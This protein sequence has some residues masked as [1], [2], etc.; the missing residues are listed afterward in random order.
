M[1][2][3]NSKSRNIKF[4]V[5]VSCLSSL[6]VACGGGGDSDGGNNSSV[7]TTPISI[8]T[9]NAPAVAS[10]AIDA[11][12]VADSADIFVGVQT[13]SN[14]A[15][16]KTIIDVSRMIADIYLQRV[17]EPQ[18]IAGVIQE[19]PNGGTKD[20][21][22]NGVGTTTFN[23]CNIEGLILNGNATI[24]V[25]SIPTETSFSGS[26][27]FNNFS[28]TES[29]ETITINGAMNLSW[30]EENLVETGNMNGSTL[31]VRSTYGSTDLKNFNFDYTSDYNS[32]LET[33][34]FEYTVNSTY[35]NGSVHVKST[36]TIRQYDY[37]DYPFEGQV[38]ITGANSSKARLTAQGGGNANDFVLIE[39][40]V[41][42]DGTYEGSNTMTW[43]ELEDAD[44]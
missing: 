14:D 43:A 33:E 30:T 2:L 5:A 12:F 34:N 40:D 22:S 4:F 37:Q 20:Y 6:L 10:H 29:G 32:S 26:M 9:Q 11:S 13:T 16:K 1:Q 17:A 24:S 21:P 31:S 19:C 42:G 28:M 3:Q 35:L 25:N 15:D 44:L 38:V 18:I 23:N 27:S 36:Q 39:T 41:D 8:T 7:P